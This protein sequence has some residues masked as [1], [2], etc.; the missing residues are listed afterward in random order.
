MQIGNLQADGFTRGKYLSFSPYSRRLGNQEQNYTGNYERKQ[1]YGNNS[2]HGHYRD[3]G[4][5]NYAPTCKGL[6]TEDSAMSMTGD[7]VTEV[8]MTKETSQM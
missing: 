4:R 2:Y 7:T 8:S 5:N 1:N 6:H 3:N